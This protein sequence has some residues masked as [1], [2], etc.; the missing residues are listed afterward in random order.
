MYKILLNVSGQVDRPLPVLSYGIQA[1]CMDTWKYMCLKCFK[2]VS[3]FFKRRLYKLSC[4][5]NLFVALI[6]PQ[7]YAKY[8]N[9]VC[10]AFSKRDN[11]NKLQYALILF[12]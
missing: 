1:M 8:W 4:V 5:K 11:T 9:H 3:T 2:P 7:K 12:L 6:Y 10:N